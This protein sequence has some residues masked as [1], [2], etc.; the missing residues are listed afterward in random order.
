MLYLTIIGGLFIAWLI[1]AVLF[2]PHIPYHI[3]TAIDARSEHCVHVLEST[4]QTHLEHG[5]RVEILTNGDHFYPA[6]LDAIRQARETITME[7]Y[8]FKKGEIGDQFIE[9]L[10]GRA[11]AGVR[12]TIV[13]DAIGSFGAFRKSARPLRE[14][15][16]W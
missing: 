9:A 3:E 4:C 8:I 15:G 14:A 2:M 6:M 7:C 13:M 1:L 12:V 10:C 5:N 11:H 16:C